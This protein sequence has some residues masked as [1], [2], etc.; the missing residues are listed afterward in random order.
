M[1]TTRP[2]FGSF[3]GSE[4]A[5]GEA[6]KALA[7]CAPLLPT[8]EA[9]SPEQVKA[10][11]SLGS[12]QSFAAWLQPI[13]WLLGGAVSQVEQ[14]TLSRVGKGL[15]SSIYRERDQ[16]LRAQPLCLDVRGPWDALRSPALLLE[17]AGEA[18]IWLSA[19]LLMCC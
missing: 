9:L 7:A 10:S 2:E 11:G 3:L 4:E 12:R 6:G 17:K 8:A 5:G 14:A 15:L 1:L 16:R 19:C 13:L 18:G